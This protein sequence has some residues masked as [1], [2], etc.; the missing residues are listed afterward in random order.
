[1]LPSKKKFIKNALSLIISIF[2]S[3]IIVEI[4]LRLLGFQPWKYENT[5]DNVVMFKYDEHLG[6]ISKKG[7]YHLKLENNPDIKFNV[8]IEGDGS[9]FSGSK[10]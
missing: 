9:R 2:F 7:S 4:F 6:W 10:D 5:T 3:L 8:T 1:M